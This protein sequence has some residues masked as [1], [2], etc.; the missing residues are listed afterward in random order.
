MAVEASL[1]TCD[2]QRKDVSFLFRQFYGRTVKGIG[3][4]GGIR[5]YSYNEL[6]QV[7]KHLLYGP[8]ST[9]PATPYL[10]PPNF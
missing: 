9:T 10:L 6:M 4:I 2:A 5:K 7:V 3:G 8:P 1:I